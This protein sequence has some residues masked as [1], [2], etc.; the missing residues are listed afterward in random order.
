MARRAVLALHDVFGADLAPALR[1][2]RSALQ[3]LEEAKNRAPG[4]A[5]KVRI[6][7]AIHFLKD[8]VADG[9]IR[10]S[11]L[12]EVDASGSSSS[13]AAVGRGGASPGL[14]SEGSGMQSAAVDCAV[15]LELRCFSTD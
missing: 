3:N 5:G 2:A 4:A 14:Q 11:E 12:T 13:D 6:A 10:L 9:G 7:E 1:D 15:C 8:A